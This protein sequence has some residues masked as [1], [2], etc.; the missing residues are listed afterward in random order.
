MKR[1][2]AGALALCLGLA[3]GA[4]ASKAVI[5]PASAVLE[6]RC[7]PSSPS[8]LESGTIVTIA[9]VPVPAT[10][11]QWVSGTVQLFG[12]PKLAFKRDPKDGLYKFKTMV[13]PMVQ[14]PVGKY[15]VKAWGRTAAGE[16][17]NGQMEYVVQ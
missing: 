6:L 5:K 13:P 14:I 1:A 9:A 3:L 17:I 15:E 4:C 12:A 11:M 2:L 16:E 10:E 8:S 7:N